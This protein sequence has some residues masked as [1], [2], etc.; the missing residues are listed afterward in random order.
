[1][2]SYSEDLKPTWP[3][4][5]PNEKIDY[6]MFLPP[7]RF[8]VIE[9]RVINEKLASDHCPLLVILELLPEKK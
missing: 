8:H 3:S 9:T 4:S 5:N 1:M 7:G 2:D 6:V